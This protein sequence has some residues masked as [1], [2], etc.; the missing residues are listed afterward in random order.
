MISVK[1]FYNVKTTNKN[2][3]EVTSN[4]IA[5]NEITPFTWY[6]LYNNFPVNEEL[7]PW[8]QPTYNNIQASNVDLPINNGPEAMDENFVGPMNFEISLFNNKYS[9]LIIS[10]NTETYEDFKNFISNSDNAKA[11]LNYFNNYK[12][13]FNGDFNM[14]ASQIQDV[15]WKFNYNQDYLTANNILFTNYDGD[16]VFNDP[17]LIDKFLTSNYNQ[18]I[19]KVDM[20]EEMLN[21][22]PEEMKN[23]PEYIMMLDM[24][25]ALDKNS[26][27]ILISYAFN[28][29]DEEEYNISTLALHDDIFDEFEDLNFIKSYSKLDTPITKSSDEFLTIMY[30]QIVTIPLS[31]ISTISIDNEEYTVNC[32]ANLSMFEYLHKNLNHEF[33]NENNKDNEDLA[34]LTGGTDTP[35]EFLEF[36]INN[37]CIPDAK[38][39]SLIS[40]ERGRSIVQDN[41]WFIVRFF[42]SNLFDESIIE[43]SQ[44]EYMYD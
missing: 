9:G 4:K 42:Q 16:L 7:E 13:V 37:N 38:I 19:I 22:V 2:T 5:K 8:E 32:V 34:L 28:I 11:G 27:S 33:Y 30:T 29:S 23:S 35:I 10:E 20:L 40:E 15:P 31:T 25:N 44:F 12:K 21:S 17:G 18:S 24:Y 43:N 39:N 1:G 36:I 3:L 6:E 41:K 26:I 14:Q